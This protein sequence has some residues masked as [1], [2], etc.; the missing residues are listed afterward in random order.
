MKLQR[1]CRNSFLPFIFDNTDHQ[2]I[3]NVIDSMSISFVKRSRSVEKS[4]RNENS[5]KGDEV[6]SSMTLTWSTLAHLQAQTRTSIC[7]LAT[8]GERRLEP[9]RV[10][11]TWSQGSLRIKNNFRIMSKTPISNISHFHALC[12]RRHRASS[13]YLS[14]SRMCRYPCHI[15][16][17]SEYWKW[18]SS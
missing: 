9:D 18:Q 11:W 4:V 5:V 17:M 7:S 1:L 6:Y 13:E 14:C 15:P 2:F 10:V 8:S 12:Q 3:E 16:G